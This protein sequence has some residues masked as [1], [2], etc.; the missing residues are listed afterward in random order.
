MLSNKINNIVITGA[1][2]FI[3]NA[4]VNFFAKKEFAVIALVRKIP[5]DKIP[6]ITYKIYEMESES[7]MN[8][9]NENSILIH[10]AYLKSEKLIYSQDIN[11]FAGKH[12]INEARRKN[13][14]NCVFM[15]SISVESTSG[16]YYS[17]Q[18]K[19][20]ENLFL[21]NNNLIVRPS[22]VI[23]NG[24]LFLK[25]ILTLRKTKILPLINGGKQPI[26][27]VG[28]DDLVQYVFYC[29]DN[30]INHIQQVTN[31]KSINYKD[32]YL[33]IAKSY[34]FK[35]ILI[36][37]PVLLMKLLVY[38]NSFLPKPII[39]QDNLKG[40]LKVPTLN[41]ENKND[42]EFEELKDILNG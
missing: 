6:N 13:I 21:Q 33:Q 39:T 11:L 32:F 29:L 36:P 19:Q 12:L 7:E 41:F 8:F 34:Q 16:A 28:I 18:K 27:Y 17:N 1:N 38:L 40:L 31:P 20:L 3:G 2:G 42:F 5:N 30:N 26:F 10:C 9:L 35:I 25:T 37:I 14:Q 23:G 22:L 15:S 4:F 24:G